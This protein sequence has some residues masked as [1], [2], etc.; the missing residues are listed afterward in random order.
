MVQEFQMTLR[1]FTWVV[2]QGKPIRST[3]A[4]TLKKIYIIPEDKKGDYGTTNP[5]SLVTEHNDRQ[6]ILTHW[7]LYILKED[8]TINYL[9]N[10]NGSYKWFD[11]GFILQQKKQI[12]LFDKDGN[13]QGSVSFKSPIKHVCFKD[14]IFL[15]ETTTKSFSFILK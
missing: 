14:N 2:T 7:F 12:T 5:I 11:N 9:K 13:S 4:E 8:K 10:E 3:K 1:E 15:V 6:Y